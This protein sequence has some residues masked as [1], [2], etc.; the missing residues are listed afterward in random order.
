MTQESQEPETSADDDMIFDHWAYVASV[1]ATHGED[2]KT[3]GLCGFHY[4]AAFA[5]GLK[6]ARE[7][8]VAPAP[9]P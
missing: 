8:R 4:R 9:N 5:H 1:L 6:H 7:E 2:A 3:I